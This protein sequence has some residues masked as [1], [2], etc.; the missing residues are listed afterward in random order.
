MYYEEFKET[1]MAELMDYLPVK[2]GNWN[3]ELREVPK[4]NGYLEGISMVSPVENSASPT[5]YVKD[6]F[7]YYQQCENMD[8]VCQRAAAIFVKGIDYALRM[9][10]QLEDELP[11]E[12]IIFTLIN[13]K[14][15]ERLLK[16]VP[17]RTFLD[18]A[19][20]YRVMIYDGEG[21]INTATITNSLAEDYRLSEE[22]L[23]QL[24]LENT[25]RLL[26]AEVHTVDGM[27][28]IL[29]NEQKILGATSMLYPGV[30]ADI[31]ETLNGNLFILPSSIHEVFLIPVD[32]Q[33]MEEMNDTI[34][35]ANESFCKDEEILSNH[36]YFYDCDAD[37][38][39]IP[40]S[41]E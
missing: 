35:E 31:A 15:N 29:T 19:L 23:Y 26:P 9:E 22:K 36:V 41:A 3:M 5:I 2:Y 21:G 34:A 28:A 33:K 32:G 13:Q 38:V 11:F 10:E 16:D 1:L 20:I 6:L 8:R 7:R 30:L 12:N 27:M 17:H 25:P 40:F 37:L 39:R 24:A 4:V 14:E 18:M